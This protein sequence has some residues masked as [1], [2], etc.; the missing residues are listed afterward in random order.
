M[1]KN[2]NEDILGNKLIK[3]NNSNLDFDEKLQINFLEKSQRKASQ[4]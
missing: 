4:Y 3:D 1:M 2:E